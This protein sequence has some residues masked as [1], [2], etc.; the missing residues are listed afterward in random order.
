[1]E[2][3]PVKTI[4]ELTELMNY[5]GIKTDHDTEKILM[6]EGYYPII[7]G[8]KDLFLE[9]K[10]PEKFKEKVN[11]K[12]IYRVFVFD[13]E[14]RILFLRKLIKVES[15]LKCFVFRNFTEAYR[16]PEAYLNKEN[17][18]I[19]ENVEKLIDSLKVKCNDRKSYLK[20]YK[21]KHGA[22]PLWVLSNNITF[23]Q[24]KHFY[25]LLEIS[26]QNKIAKEIGGTYKSKVF[27]KS[28][29]ISLYV[30]SEFRNTCAHDERLYNSFAETYSKKYNLYDMYNLLSQFLTESEKY[31]LDI[32]LFYLFRRELSDLNII[33]KEKIYMIMG[34]PLDW[35]KKVI[36]I[37]NKNDEK[38]NTDETK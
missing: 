7:N 8:Y 5:R 21:N 38:E 34:F 33:S 27:P 9:T 2:I 24:L 36:S 22:I 23:G 32:S 28:L 6:T 4:K 18:S 25:R 35:E 14:L 16:S 20:H 37:E 17:Y 31:Y 19:N 1:M 26:L 10:D 11:F 30:C 13:R 3:K 29:R 15:R 12:D